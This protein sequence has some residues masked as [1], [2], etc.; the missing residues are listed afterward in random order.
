MTRMVGTGMAC[1]LLLWVGAGEKDHGGSTWGYSGNLG[2]EHWSDLS[3]EYIACRDGVAQSPVNI[4][5]ATKS[6][7]ALKTYYKAD[8]KATI[9]NNGH[10]I[11]VNFEDG[12]YMA[13]TSG[14]ESGKKFKLAQFHFHHRSEHS[15]EGKSYPMEVHLV[16]QGVEDPSQLAVIGV[17]LDLGE[18]NPFI[19]TL[20]TAIFNNSGAGNLPPINGTALLPDDEQIYVYSGSLTT[21]NCAESVRWHVFKESISL[22]PKQVE[23]FKQ[24]F[25]FNR[26]PLQPLNGRTISV[27]RAEK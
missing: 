20:W 4:V 6:S 23:T 24:V 11:Q 3:E 5:N 26:R 17:F 15:L 10:T 27:G 25:P 1:F 19:E 9:V 7:V 2:P 8:P 12:G 22:S 14:A 13:Y 16:H 21:P 18:Q